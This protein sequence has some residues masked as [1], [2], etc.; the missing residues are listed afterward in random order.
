[1]LLLIFNL[2]NGSNLPISG[3][4]KQTI[5]KADKQSTQWIS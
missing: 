3:T 2:I 5:S 4:I 1:M